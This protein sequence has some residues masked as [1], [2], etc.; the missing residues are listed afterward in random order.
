MADLLRRALED[1]GWVA[2]PG[3]EG[4]VELRLKAPAQAEGEREVGRA[5]A[6]PGAALVTTEPAAPIWTRLRG[7]GWRVVGASDGSTLLYPHGSAEAKSLTAE[8]QDGRVI[9]LN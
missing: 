3:P 5:S 9:V 7:S 2:E 1:V 6:A 4:T 8:P